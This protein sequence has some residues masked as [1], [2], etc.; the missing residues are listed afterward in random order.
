M[1]ILF[2]CN[3]GEGEPVSDSMGNQEVICALQDDNDIIVCFID[4]M[5]GKMYIE[6]VINTFDL[7]IF[8]SKNFTVIKNDEQWRT[9]Y[10]AFQQAEALAMKEEGKKI[11]SH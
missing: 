1:K 5:T 11:I 4:R 6:R 7:N 10:L 8:R 2:Y 9:Y 3:P